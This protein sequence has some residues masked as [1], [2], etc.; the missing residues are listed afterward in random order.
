[1]DFQDFQY[2]NIDK[3]AQCKRKVIHNGSISGMPG[4]SCLPLNL[5][6]PANPFIVFLNDAPCHGIF[7]DN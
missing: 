6:A 7:E 4:D 3:K 1:M 5:Y 2:S